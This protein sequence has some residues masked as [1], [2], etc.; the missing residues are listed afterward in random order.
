MK[1]ATAR[2]IVLLIF[3][4]HVCSINHLN[5]PQTVVSLSEMIQDKRQVGEALSL[6]T[7]QRDLELHHKRSV[8]ES[9]ILCPL[10]HEVQAPAKS[11]VDK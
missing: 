3:S 4:R 6:A 7:Y 10:S 11:I 8:V 1:I 5:R 9:S 2:G